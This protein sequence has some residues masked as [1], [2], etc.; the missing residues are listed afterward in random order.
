MRFTHCFTTNP[1]CMPARASYVTGQYPSHHGVWQNGV[2][3]SRRVETLQGALGRG[4]YHTGL[5]GKIHLDNV[6]LRSEPHPEYEF[7]VLRECEGDPYCKDEYFHWLDAQGLYEPYMAQFK[8]DGHRAGYVRDLPEEKHMNNWI[9]GL[10]EEYFQQRVA[11]GRPFFLSAGFFDPHH[12]F[13]PVEPYASMFKPEEMPMPLYRDGEE[14]RMTLPAR[15]RYNGIHAYCTDPDPNGI[16]KTIAAYH[17]TVTHVDAM[18]GRLLA[19][20][21]ETGLADNTVVIF[22]SDHGEM[23][24]DHGIL[25]KGPLFYEGAVRVP[26]IYRF[27]EHVGLTGVREGFVSH[28]DFAPTVAALTGVPGPHLAQGQPLFSETLEPQPTRDA[29]LVEWREKRFQSDD[30]FTVARCLVTEDWKYVH[31][32]DRDFGELYDRHNDPDEFE[33]LW[34][35]R[36]GVVAEM[37]ERLLAFIIENEP[38][39]ARTDIF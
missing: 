35:D 27:P 16:R 23:L 28:V 24:G 39:P 33:N 15:E 29:A 37:K 5:I 31:Y 32:H 21:E 9:A 19:A 26:L 38:C 14:E 7:D 3:L 12:P 18:V 11:D 25:W 13:D 34:A 20:L 22:T 10:C 6:W 17:A 1:V 4:G 30:P 2:P 8:R 36:P